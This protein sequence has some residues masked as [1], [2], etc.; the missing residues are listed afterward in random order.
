M[1]Y[2]KI[3]I[4]IPVKEKN[5]NLEECIE[6]CLKLDYPDYEII[7]LPDR[8]ERFAYFRAKRENKV[9]EQSERLPYPK[10]R[11][12]STGA[13][14]PSEKRDIGIKHARGE[15]LAF[16]DD[17]TFPTK[18]WLKNA[19]PYFEDENIAAIGGAG[20][21]PPNDGLREQASGLVYSSLLAAGSVGYRYVPKRERKVDDFPTCNFLVRKSIMDSLGGFGVKFWPGEDTKLCLH[22]VRDLGKKI[23]YT[24]R[25]LVYHHRRPLFI[26]HLRQVRGYG[27]H[28]GYFAKRFPHTSR[29]F[30]YFI[31]SLFVIG[32]SLGW[33]FGL[34]QPLFYKIYFGTI[35]FYLL[36]V[37][38]T[39]LKNRDPKKVLLV[40]FG[41]I[42]TN[43]T[44]GVLFLKGLFSR[45]LKEE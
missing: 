28:R 21:T 22:I 35:L 26:P 38:L 15:I 36:I 18:D 16:L 20:I 34:I 30:P 5:R 17:D 44:Y 31:P 2:P 8:K 12:I 32:L 42:A 6:Y 45:R 25:V 14:G 24:P 19:I 33:L 40:F 9:L 29:R 43:L 23:I 39:S 27:L 41:I 3:S 37:L 7:V 10:T 1:T 4:I 13:I 11:V